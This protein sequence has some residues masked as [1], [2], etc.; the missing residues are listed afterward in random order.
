MAAA[1]QH[2]WRFFRAGGFDQV[3]LDTGAD[4]ANLEHLDQKLWVALSCPAR[5]IEF[6]EKTL[7]L[8]DLDKD[9]RIRYVEILAAARFACSLLKNPGELLK[10]SASLPLSAISDSTPEGKRL[11][12]SAKQ[13]LND[14]GKGT[15]IAISVDDT[16]DTTKIFSAT[17]FNGDG[18]VP[19]DSTTNPVTQAVLQ[20]IIDCM[21][22]E[23]DRSGKPGV[24]QAK[25]DQFF[26]EIATYTAWNSL[27]ETDPSILPLGDQTK[28]ASDA[29]NAV[30]SKAEDYFA[31][32]KLAAFDVRSVAAMNLTEEEYLRVASKDFSLTADEVA[33]FPLS[34]ID[35]NRPLPLTGGLNPAWE[36][37]IAAF[38]KE[39]VQ[40]I[41]GPREELT[42]ADFATVTA[43]LV[44]YDKWLA[45]RPMTSLDRLGPQRVREIEQLNAKPEIDLLLAEDIRLSE[46][47]QQIETV[48][49][50]VRLNRDLYRLLCNFVNFRDFYARQDKAIFQVGTLYLDQR[51]CD[52]CVRVEDITKHAT[53]ATLSRA[54]LAYCEC[55]RR[56]GDAEK[57]T[58]AAAFT[59]GDSDYLM[60]GRNGVFY[61]RKGC[62]WDA[63]IIK[64]VDNPIS[65]RQAFWA[66]YKRAMR[67]IEEQI[68]KH[69]VA[70]DAAATNKLT[71]TATTVGTAATTPLP[72]PAPVTAPA[73]VPVKPKF[74]VGVV[75]AMGVA[76]G[77]VTAAFGAILQAFFGLGPWMP[78]GFFAAILLISGPSMLVAWLKLRQRNLGPILDANGWAVNSRAMI[79]IPF[80]SVLTAIATLPPGARRDI[81]DPYA[82]K[83]SAWNWIL[84]ILLW[85]ATLAVLGGAFW[86]FGG[87]EQIAPGKF[88]KSQWMLDNEKSDKAAADKAAAE[89][90]KAAPA[91]K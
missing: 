50:L 83:K 88:R 45:A 9:G 1:T 76:I 30:R 32:C 41:L 80:G 81:F 70:A 86:N 8:I 16:S 53:L 67:W 57:I 14:L 73:S 58:I 69:A 90:A 13:I 31:R 44:P 91:T 6:D 87:L 75:A 5:G 24:N 60:V 51:S 46:Y 64:I 33:H 17:I 43:K 68:T 54:Y 29:L 11:Q 85:V 25:V 78:I 59:A 89:K 39:T 35:A 55:T 34:R 18:I 42:E 62:D 36:A 84:S 72:A 66:P 77:G 21:G 26:G 7:E 63:T 38:V 20:N 22:A 49:K 71:T 15:A 61:D 3:R 52:L 40:P 12:Q 27:V 28:A 56:S 79:S 74:D 48:D 65:V 10:G 23:N 19:I 82:P 2:T 47:S 4:I 37:R